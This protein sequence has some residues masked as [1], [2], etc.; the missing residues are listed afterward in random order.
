MNPIALKDLKVN[1]ESV[2]LYTV[3]VKVLKLWVAY[4]H[5]NK[6]PISLEAVFVDNEVR[7]V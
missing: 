4:E 1:M 5:Q 2:N 7:L 3:T 6:I